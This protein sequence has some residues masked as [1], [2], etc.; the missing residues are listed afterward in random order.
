MKETDHDYQNCL[1]GNFYDSNMTGELDSWDDFTKTHS[2]FCQNGYDDTYNFIFRY[3]IHKNDDKYTL[4]LCMML[5]RKGI[6][7]HLWVYNI[8]QDELDT[9]VHDWLLGRKQYIDNLWGI[10]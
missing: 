9:V 7:A 4:E 10:K 2:G 3:D 1:C 8:T 6:Y 5:Q